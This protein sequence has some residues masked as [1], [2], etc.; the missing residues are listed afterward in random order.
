MSSLSGKVARGI[1]AR[2]ATRLAQAGAGVVVNYAGRRHA[3]EQV[4]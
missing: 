2:I 1:G 4:V 3:A